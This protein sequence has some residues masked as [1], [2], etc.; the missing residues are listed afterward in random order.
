[1]D[2]NANAFLGNLFILALNPRTSSSNRLRPLQ[3]ILNHGLMGLLNFPVDIPIRIDG[4]YKLQEPIG[5]GSYVLDLLGPSL[6]DILAQRK[7][8]SP[9]IVHHLGDQL[10]SQIQYIHSNGYI[11]GDIKPQNILVGLG[12]QAITPYLINFGVSK[13]YRD[14]ATGDHIPFRHARRSH[15][16]GL[17]YLLLSTA[18]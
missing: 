1:M 15:M 5:S 2:A 6:Q 17:L 18:I 14:S 16:I 3:L 13:Q 11:H 10:L 8:L 4:R 9:S 12:D 7:T